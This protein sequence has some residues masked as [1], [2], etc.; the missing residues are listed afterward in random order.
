MYLEVALLAV[1]D[2]LLASNH[3]HGHAAQLGVRRARDEVGRACAR[4]GTLSLRLT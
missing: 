4:A 1:Q 2:G 3:E